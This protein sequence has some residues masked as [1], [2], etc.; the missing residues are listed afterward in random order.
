M[1]GGEEQVRV[2]GVARERVAPQ[3]D[4]RSWD[5]CGWLER[6]EPRGNEDSVLVGLVAFWGQVIAGQGGRKADRKGKMRVHKGPEPNRRKQR[7]E[8]WRLWGS[9]LMRVGVAIV[10]NM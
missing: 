2:V 9:M 6:Q 10:V 4:G 3:R 1:D 8:R 7:R 5:A